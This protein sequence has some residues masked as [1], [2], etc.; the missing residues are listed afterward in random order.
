MGIKWKQR[1]GGELGPG[2]SYLR[3]FNDVITKV[4]SFN[5]SEDNYDCW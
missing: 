4:A 3:H 1:E 5:A 2:E